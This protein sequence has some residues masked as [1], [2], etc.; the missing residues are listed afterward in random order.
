[1]VEGVSNENRRNFL[2]GQTNEWTGDGGICL[3]YH[4]FPTV[5]VS[6]SIVSHLYPFVCFVGSSIQNH[7]ILL[8]GGC[9]LFVLGQIHGDVQ[10]LLL[11]YM[12]DSF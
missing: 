3:N 8:F 11:L 10:C 7:I 12:L 1:M 9:C 6:L 2:L 4:Q 5:L